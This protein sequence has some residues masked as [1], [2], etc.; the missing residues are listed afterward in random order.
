MILFY[1]FICFLNQINLS[2]I[3]IHNKHKIVFLQGG[4]DDDGSSHATCQYNAAY[5]DHMSPTIHSTWEHS[6]K[7]HH[8][9]DR[10][11]GS[12]GRHM[13]VTRQTKSTV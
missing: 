6:H 3:Q 2:H 4:E 8:Q 9:Y 11:T 12:W 1:P 13:V 5:V 7:H 10:T